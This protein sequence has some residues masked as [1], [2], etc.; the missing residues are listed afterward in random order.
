[1]HTDHAQKTGA[2]LAHDAD[3]DAPMKAPPTNPLPT[4]LASAVQ[5]ALDLLPRRMD[6]ARADVAATINALNKYFDPASRRT[7][8]AATA[9]QQLQ[10][11]MKTAEL[12]QLDDSFAALATAAAGR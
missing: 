3:R 5:P 4:V 10:S 2:P 1:M 7:Q 8:G 12:P 11:H 9:L 6:S